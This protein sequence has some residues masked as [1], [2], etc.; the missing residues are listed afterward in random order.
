LQW[1]LFV[2]PGIFTRV[3]PAW[4]FWFVPWFHPNRIDSRAVLQTARRALEEQS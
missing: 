4:L 1:W 3:L 2:H